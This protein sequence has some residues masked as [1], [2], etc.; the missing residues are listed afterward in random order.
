[1]LLTEV[2][3][4]LARELE[5]LLKQKKEFDLAAEVATLAI[6]DRCRCGDDFCASFYRQPKPEGRY[7]G[8]HR[9]VDL[10][11]AKGMLILDVVRRGSRTS[12]SF[13]ETKSARRSSTPSRDGVGGP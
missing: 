3:P 8:N 5:Q 6:V 7:G 9:S 12:R 2:L 4:E 1:M 10:D 13:I 11:A